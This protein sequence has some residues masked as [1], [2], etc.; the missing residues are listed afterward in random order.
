[1]TRPRKINL[2]EERGTE[3]AEDALRRKVDALV[4][5]LLLLELDV[6]VLVLVVSRVMGMRGVEGEEVRER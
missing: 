4:W 1:M 2:R 5:L 3:V 6:V